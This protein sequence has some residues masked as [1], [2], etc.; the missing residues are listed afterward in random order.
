MTH[1][2][3]IN[4]RTPYFVSTDPFSVQYRF[5]LIISGIY[6]APKHRYEQSALQSVLKLQ[7]QLQLTLQYNNVQHNYYLK[8]LKK[9]NHF[10]NKC[11]FR[12]DLKVA[13]LWDVRSALSNL[14]QRNGRRIAKGIVTVCS[15]SSIRD[16]EIIISMWTQEYVTIRIIVR[17]YEVLYKVELFHVTCS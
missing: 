1:L 12:F 10:R 8:N 15:V 11:V 2:I 4:H 17:F 14:F 16:K 13:R 6:T 5:P 9:Q 3:V 7:L